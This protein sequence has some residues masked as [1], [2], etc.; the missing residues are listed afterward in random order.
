[1]SLVSVVIPNYNYGRYV[2]A[3]VDSVLSQ[4]HQNIEVIVVDNGSTDDSLQRLRRF[5]D[6]IRVIPQENRGQAGARNRGISESRGDWVAFCDADDCWSPTKLE[7]QLARFD[8]PS[9]GLVYTGYYL[10]DQDLRPMRQVK[11]KNRGRVLPLFAEGSAAVIPAGESSVLIRR[12][13][14]E[15]VGGFDEKLSISAGFDFYRR[16][17]QYFEVEAVAEP[18]V[19]YRQH[20]NSASR[21]SDAFARDYLRALEKMF[22][23]PDASELLAL[24]AACLGRAHVSLSGAFF[25]SRDFS[26]SLR[27]L[28]LG[29]W[30]SPRELKYVLSIGNRILQR[31]KAARGAH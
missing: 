28:L 10:C 25:Q 12:A 29:L 6:R 26:A 16:I 31:R 30:W 27:H 19:F 11:A 13:V 18:L 9:V 17:C 3:A 2:C 7:E 1:M 5:G 21:R 8:R 4:T 23:D 14:L 24:R 15:Q 22:S 20:P